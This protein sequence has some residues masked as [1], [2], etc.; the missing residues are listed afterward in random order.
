MFSSSTFI[1]VTSLS[2][3][4]P[5]HVLV[6]PLSLVFQ[7]RLPLLVEQCSDDLYLSLLLHCPTFLFFFSES[8]RLIFSAA[9]ELLSLVELANKVVDQCQNNHNQNCATVS[10]TVFLLFFDFDGFF[11]FFFIF[12]ESFLS[13]CGSS[14]TTALST[15]SS[16]IGGTISFLFTFWFI[17][18]HRF[19]YGGFGYWWNHVQLI[20]IYRCYLIVQSKFGSFLF[21]FW[22]ILYHRFLYGGFGYW[23]N[24]V[25]L[26]YIYR[27]YFIVQ[28]APF[29][30]FG[31]SFITGFS[32]AA[33]AIGGTMFR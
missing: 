26:I 8:S 27:C 33:S 13:P 15:A 29:P 22:F 14:F 31:S 18:Y 24:H 21:T 16:A 5:F 20:Y 10:S 1:A 9:L 17:L 25:Q 28:K 2:N 19:L 12:L 4:L 11:D 6:H 23:W 7:R 32:T 30:P 3:K